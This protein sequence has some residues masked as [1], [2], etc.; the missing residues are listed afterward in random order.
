[1]RG[2]DLHVFRRALL[3]WFR[4]HR[5]DLP[6]RRTRDP[7]RVWLSE[8]ML[9]QTRVAAV[10]PYY[11]R[12]LRRFP[13]LRA[14]ARAPVRDVLR[15]WAGL[16]Y[17]RRA[18]SLHAAARE[19]VER[20]GGGFPRTRQEALALPGVGRYTAAAVLSI[21][22]HAPLAV[23]DGNVA[24]VLARLDGVTGDLRA[25]RRW[26]QLECR[27]QELLAA[28][29]PANWNQA[30][31]ELGATVCTPRAPRCGEC[32]VA[33]YCRARALGRV[34][35]IPPVRRRRA[36]V[37]MRV[38]A[39]VLVD[40]EGRTLLLRGNRGAAGEL[41]SSMWQ[42]PA[43]EGDADALRWY[44]AG[45]NGAPRAEEKT[46]TQRTRRKHGEDSPPSANGTRY[47]ALATARH[48][49]TFRDI[50]F[51]P[52]LVHVGQLPRIAGA[53]ALRLDALDALPISSATRK[54]AAAALAHLS[55]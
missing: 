49:V 34:D 23:V 30:V 35:Q 24:R 27:A 55:K 48:A 4:R 1:M 33:R 38:A 47:I 42:F 53:R 45:L 36:A 39:A 22:Y 50:T 11:T 16:G 40:A 21:A 41:F 14:L 18:R 9:Q 32:P 10:I 12:F 46:L 29:A 7:Y 19:I 6:W 25:P 13:A 52:Y 51:L 54:I 31:M 8:I 17:Y 37:K 28:R 44:V 2:A 15:H 26:K 20:H 5:R 43:V 3:A